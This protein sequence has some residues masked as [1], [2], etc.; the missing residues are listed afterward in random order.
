MNR[1]NEKIA[2]IGT[3]T[4]YGLRGLSDLT[5][6]QWAKENPGKMTMIG[7]GVGATAIPVAQAIY[8]HDVPTR[9]AFAAHNYEKAVS[10]ARKLEQAGASTARIQRAAAKA[11]RLQARARELK[12][13]AEK[14]NRAKKLL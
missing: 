3:L 8:R 6:T 12:L 4:A 11:S 5:Q 2:G 9:A 14:L 7:G 13:I 1:M 10:K